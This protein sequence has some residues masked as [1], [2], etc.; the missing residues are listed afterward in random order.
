MRFA[1]NTLK[2]TANKYN[3]EYQFDVWVYYIEL[4]SLS[5]GMLSKWAYL[6]V[7]L[8]SLS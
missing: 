3:L 7:K 5:N 1:L 2:Y 8:S 4:T 6:W